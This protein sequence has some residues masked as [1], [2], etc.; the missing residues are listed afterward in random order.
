MR[1]IAI[2]NKKGGSGKT[3]TT[4]NLAAALAERGQKVLII[5]LDEQCNSTTWCDP[6]GFNV[7]DDRGVFDL[8]Y[9]R[10]K[11]VEDLVYQTNAEGVS[12]VPASPWLAGIDKSLSK[13]P[14]AEQIL[15]LKLRKLSPHRF[16]HVLFDCPP[17]VGL[18]TVNGLNA[19]MEVLIPV[20]TTVMNLNGLAQILGYIEMVR[21]RL[22]P[23]IRVSGIL[24]CRYDTR[25][26]RC[27]DVM[28]KLRERFPDL[29]FKT[30]IRENTKLAEAPSFGP[31]LD[32]DPDGAAT[33]DYRQFAQEILAQ[34]DPNYALAAN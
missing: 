15:K 28:R 33:E 20:E 27:K 34:E 6:A 21:E 26:R 12:I 29:V 30:V 5:D 11:D 2:S 24:G 1:A 14:G 32:Y 7:V 19:A 17:N 8:F 13:E 31:V 18:M 16:T 4:V 25:L 9:D 3:S 22:N 23:E 10:K